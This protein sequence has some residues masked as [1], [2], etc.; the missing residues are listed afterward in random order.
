MPNQ[1]KPLPPEDEIKEYVQFYYDLGQNDREIQD[2]MKDH[3]NTELYGLSVSSIKRLRKKWD[4]LST[5]QQKHTLESIAPAIQE[6]RTRFPTR[7]VEMIRKQLRVEFNIRVPRSVVYNYL[8]MTEPDALKAR[9]ARRFKRRRYHAAGVNDTWAQDQHDKW[10]PRFGLWLHH[11]ADPF[12][13]FLNWLKVWWTNKNPCL[14]A[15]YFIDTARKYGAIPLTTQSDPGSENF[16]VANIQTLARHRLDPTLVG[17]LQHRWLRH[18]ANIK[19]EINWSVFRRDFAPGYEDLFQQ[20][21]VS[22]WYEVT[23]VVENL[24]FRWIAIPW[25]QN[26]LDKWANTKN[27]T[28]PRSDRKKILPLGAPLLIRTKPEKFNALDFKIPVTEDLLDD[29]E[30]EYAPKDHPVFQLTPPAFDERARKI[31]EDIGT[32]EVTMASFWEIYRTMLERFCGEVDEEIEVV[33]TAR[34]A[35]EQGIDQEEISLLDG[36]KDLRQGDKVV[37]LQ[38]HSDDRNYASFTDTDE[39]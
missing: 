13:G 2:N 19:P 5:R 11:S 4:L 17:T 32:P 21:V 29:L 34:V 7:G 16:G 27:R 22:G 38:E 15:G 6:M 12:T 25:L 33:L 37:G 9:K 39:E 28:A 8:Q 31:Y 30:N 14:I 26:E 24:V 18:K 35:E 36:M 10:G 23:N 1:H 20:G 3:Y